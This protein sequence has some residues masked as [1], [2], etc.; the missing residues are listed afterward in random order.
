MSSINQENSQSRKGKVLIAKQ[1][2]DTTSDESVNRDNGIFDNKIPFNQS[3]HNSSVSH[4]GSVHDHTDEG[5]GKEL[6][7]NNSKRVYYRNMIL[8]FGREFVVF[9]ILLMSTYATYQNM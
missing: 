9:V 8:Y 3:D 7:N 1:P 4:T 5:I 6:I 2:L